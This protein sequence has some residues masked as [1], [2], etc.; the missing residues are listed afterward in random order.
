MVGEL[1]LTTNVD[2][3]I[4]R[5]GPNGVMHKKIGEGLQA[6]LVESAGEWEL[7]MKRRF[8]NYTGKSRSN[9]LQTRSGQH[10]RGISFRRRGRGW[11]AS[12][13]LRAVGPG[14]KVHES[15]KPTTI[16]GKPWLS[17]P[18]PHTLTK[19]GARVSAKYQT[20]KWFGSR[21][22]TKLGPT[23]IHPSKRNS[24]NLI[25]FGRVSKT[26]ISALRV[27]TKS[28]TIPGGRL[29]AR[30]TWRE[31]RPARLKKYRAAIR[32]GRGITH[33][34]AGQLRGAGGRFLS[35]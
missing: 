35:S 29:G 33:H 14:A 2:K 15:D 4:K 21:W 32:K 28:V 20:W 1:S 7:K 12:V 22:A 17:I 27:L 3:L 8:V 24:Q 6:A 25:V 23:W 11:N 13:L 5:I 18:L 31:L 30:K 19:S 10:R 26:K 9:R 16:K 34:S